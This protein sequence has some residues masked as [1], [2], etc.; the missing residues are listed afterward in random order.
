MTTR[1]VVPPTW[2]GPPA[3]WVR[4]EGWQPSAEWGPA[5][6]GWQFWQEDAP[7]V[8]VPQAY[9]EATASSIPTPISRRSW[10]RRLGWLMVLVGGLASY[11]LVNQTMI[12]TQNV[13]FFLSLIHI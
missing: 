8:V 10:E 4:T 13:L 7:P 5:P 2:P 12:D 11:F 1:F 6:V 9:P 3:G